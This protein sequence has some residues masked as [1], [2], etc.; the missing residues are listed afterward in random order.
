MNA[1]RRLHIWWLGRRI[2]VLCD[3]YDAGIDNGMPIADRDALWAQVRDLIGQ[4]EASR[5]FL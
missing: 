3:R 1:L 4:R 2:K 5:W